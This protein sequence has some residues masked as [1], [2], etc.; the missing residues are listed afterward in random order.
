[1]PAFPVAPAPT[2]GAAPRIFDLSSHSRAR[3]ALEFGLGVPELGFNIFVVGEDR[4]GRMT[5]TM[6]LLEVHAQRLPRPSDWIYLPNF[7][8]PERPRPYRLPAGVGRLFRDRLQAL[9]PALRQAL[10]RAFE[11][12]EFTTHL[13]RE[14]ATLQQAM[15]QAFAEL[16]AFAGQH[17]YAI[18]RTPQGM[19][20][21]PQPGNEPEALEKLSDKERQLR[22]EGLAEVRQRVGV[23]MQA[24]RQADLKFAETMREARRQTADATLMPL[25]DT[26]GAEF[27]SYPGLARWIV[28]FRNDLVEHLEL[29]AGPPDPE[30]EV[31]RRLAAEQRYAVNLLVDHSEEPHAP[32]VLEPTPS[33][34]NL[35][36]R[37][38]FRFESGVAVT[39]YRHI[40]AGSLHRANEGILVLR[41]EA[42]AAQPMVWGFLKAALRDRCI[43]IEPP[44]LG[45]P[46]QA[47]AT[48]PH[49]IPLAVKVVI[50]GAPRWYYSVFSIDP[51]FSI[52]FK[53]KA[54]IDPDLPAKAQDLPLYARLVHFMALRHLSGGITDAAVARLLAEAARWAEHRKKLS[55]RFEQ[56]EDLVAEAAA[57]ARGDGAGKIDTPQV[58]KILAERRLR[59]ARIEDRT[60]EAIRE[61]LVL[62][63][64]DGARVGQVNGLTV[65][66]V[67]DHA[68]GAPVRISARVQAGRLGIINVERATELGG[69]IQQKGVY[70]IGGYLSG[71]FARRLPLS[72][73]ATITFE[74]SY[75]GVEG[76]SASMGELVAVISA[77]ADVPL[78]QDIAITG[79]V[80][81]A[82]E[83]QPIGG[84]IEKIEGFFRTC[85]ER[86]LTG[87]QGVLI[88]AANAAHV[89]L[90]EEVTAAVAAGKFQIWTMRDVSDALELL[91]GIDPGR[92]GIDGAFPSGSVMA[93]VEATL[94][95]FDRL[96]QERGG[97]AT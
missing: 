93:R 50:V 15:G 35:F 49:S 68:F 18:E 19:M 71:C 53:I 2:D 16:N 66:D 6:A 17:G 65:R 12:A 95:H 33:Y 79:S 80:N 55:A 51:D 27:G 13:E 63:D 32:V 24:A 61:G 97:R 9:L 57:V 91:T 37:F 38:E 76:D 88:P 28:E 60:Q 48:T 26:I 1:P 64:T 31:A 21:R 36:G 14:S 69:P 25:I 39:D 20:L 40:R 4:S 96:L 41:A 47:G 29:L 8:H 54:E 77:L 73:T 81:Q 56:V 3:E 84:A 90:S 59:H 7:R 82:G 87:K 5:A 23:F 11:A 43:R 10:A 46:P 52:Y 70:I 78:R 34:E 30:A 22:L 94:G 44:H 58:L 45:G 92:G 89:I 67:G 72:F 83:S 62:I 85:A 86:G 42:L 75:G 74:Q